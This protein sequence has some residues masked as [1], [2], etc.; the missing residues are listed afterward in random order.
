MGVQVLSKMVT[1]MLVN[2]RPF[3]KEFNCKSDG[4]PIGTPDS[5]FEGKL[6][7]THLIKTINYVHLKPS[8]VKYKSDGTPIGTPT[9]MHTDVHSFERQVVTL[10]TG[11]QVKSTTS[12]RAHR[13][14]HPFQ[15]Y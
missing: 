14:A 6:M 9:S 1:L 7:W 11:S 13:L 15:V 8:E 3:E 12:L 4:T 2:Q 5:K 10:S